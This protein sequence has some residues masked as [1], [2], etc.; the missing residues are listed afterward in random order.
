MRNLVLW[1][2]PVVP[3]TGLS[4]PGSDSDGLGLLLSHSGGLGDG[5]GVLLGDSDSGSVGNGCGFSHSCGSSDGSSGPDSDGLSL[6]S[7][8]L[9]VLRS[10][11]GKASKGEDGGELHFDID[12][13]KS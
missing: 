2:L 9:P 11:K 13:G 12:L 1:G 8:L 5:L 3:L 6:L 4:L 10:G 7:P